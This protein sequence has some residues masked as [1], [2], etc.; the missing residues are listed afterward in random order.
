MKFRKLKHCK[1]ACGAVLAAASISVISMPH[2]GQA[3]AHS[4]RYTNSD[5]FTLKGLSGRQQ[6][7]LT[8]V[9]AL[10]QLNNVPSSGRTNA[11]QLK[12]AHT[13]GNFAA[14]TEV[15][16]NDDKKQHK[17]SSARIKD[18][19]KSGS[20]SSRIADIL[21]S[22]DENTMEFKPV[23]SYS[24]SYDF[25][26]SALGSSSIMGA[27]IA[28]QEQCVRYLLEMNPNPKISVSPEELVKYYYEEA[29]RE[30]IRPDA[31]FAQALK[32]T[33]NFNYGG[34]VTPD[35]NNYCGL[36]TTSAT[37]K[38]AYFDTAQLGVRA[39]I[40]HL[41]AYSSVRLPREDV[42]DPRYSLVR[43]AYSGS[44]IDTWQGLNGRWA[45]PGNNYG[46]E[47]LKILNRIARE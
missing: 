39:H 28:S 7:E 22:D 6:G 42:V 34:T 5:N 18:E 35:Q 26:Q 9:Q 27:P 37:V 36:G 3:A 15:K 12:T 8:A 17:S 47:I 21:A 16:R 31:A 2:T 23:G 24:G 32:E 11:V 19:E 45:V 46:Q 13:G 29:G 40:Q 1:Y 33:G 14:K 43:A 30:G 38:G 10:A 20:V 25:S 44:T 41:L 4:M